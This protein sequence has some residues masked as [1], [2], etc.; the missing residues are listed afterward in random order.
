MSDKDNGGPAFPVATQ[1]SGSGEYGHQC[2]ANEWQFP[3]ISTRDYF[4]AKALPQVIAT[5]ASDTRKPGESPEDYFARRSYMLADAMIAV[6]NEA[7]S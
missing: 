5:C 4:A 2:A 7:A 6:R 3:G 1:Q